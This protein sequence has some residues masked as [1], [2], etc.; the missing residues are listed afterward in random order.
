MTK[1]QQV[2][3]YIYALL[4]FA[5]ILGGMLYIVTPDV[6]PYHLEAIGIPW[7]ALPAG[8]RDLLRVMVK[9]IGG[10]TIL[11]SG[12]IMTL[13]LVPFR[14]SEPWAIVTVAVTGAFYNAMGLAAALYIRHTTGARTPWIFG[15]VS[16]TLVIIAG[17]VSLSGMRQRGNRVQRA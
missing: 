14:K 1:A 4:S 8:T 7:S 12:T 15:I 11:F 10:V 17:I 9:L 3:F 5:G 2:S 6:M 13:L 16:L